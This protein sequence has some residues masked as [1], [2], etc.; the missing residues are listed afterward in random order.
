[1][2]WH[3]WIALALVAAAAWSVQIRL[4]H[5]RQARAMAGWTPVTGSVVAH[6]IDE[7]TSQDS[8]GDKDTSY[9]PCLTY[10]YEVDGATRQGT[11]IALDN[12]S[13]SSRSRAQAY[14]DERPIGSPIQVFVNPANPVEAV[15]STERKSDWWVPVMFV[16]LAAAVA[17]GL[18]GQ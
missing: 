2:E 18:F 16:V 4:R 8:D 10:A 13:F 1:M 7:T 12:L 15:L 5:A 9:A 6:G 3:H 17:A 14:L 11:R